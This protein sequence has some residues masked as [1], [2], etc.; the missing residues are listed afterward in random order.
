MIFEKYFNFDKNKP[1]IVVTTSQ[2]KSY[3]SVGNGFVFELF[4]AITKY[5]S[6]RFNI[7]Y[8]GITH[9]YLRPKEY[10]YFVNGCIFIKDRM[11]RKEKLTSYKEIIDDVNFFVLDEMNIVGL[12]EVGSLLSQSKKQYMK[13]ANQ[14]YHTYN[15]FNYS[16][17]FVNVFRMCFIRNFVKKLN[18]PLNHL[19]IDPQEVMYDFFNH[20]KYRKF[21]GHVIPERNVEKT[22]IYTYFQVHD[23]ERQKNEKTEDFTFGFSSVT[24]D[25]EALFEEIINFCNNI[26]VNNKNIFWYNKIRKENTFIK[27]HLYN[28]LISR[29]KYTLIIK[30]YDHETFSI[31]R[32]IESILRDC[33]PLI[34]YDNKFHMFNE[35]QQKFLK[36][37]IV[38]SPEHATSI[39]KQIDETYRVF[40]IKEA[41]KL[42]LTNMKIGFKFDL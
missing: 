32:F 3:N 27:K 26:N 12:I 11:K 28:D 15:G 41:K 17:T 7:L 35:E 18:I 29:S 25:R 21:F 13:I 14:L 37:L 19:I 23:P 30:P 2:N 22:D 40:L 4:S 20:D 6:D 33:L 8:L 10:Q 1:S 36:A 16:S 42:F 9:N 39:M 24:D 38:D 5:Y 31:Y 34:H